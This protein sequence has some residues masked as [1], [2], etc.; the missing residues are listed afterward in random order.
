MARRSDIDWELIQRLYIAGQLTIRQISEQC[1]VSDS[2]I[3]ARAKRDGWQRDLSDAIKSRAREKIA[4]IDV[5]AL[6][7]KSA[8]ESADESAETIRQAVEQAADAV[9]G[10]VLRHRRDIEACARRAGRLEEAFDSLLEAGPVDEEGNPAQLAVGDIA[11]LASAFKSLVEARGK[12]IDKE[13]QALGI[14]SGDGGDDG[15][16]GIDVEFV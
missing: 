3:R 9:A 10:T 4:R 8:Q 2:Q 12:L 1:G 16:S 11:K 13:R 6:I 5:S 7:E 15:I 14:E